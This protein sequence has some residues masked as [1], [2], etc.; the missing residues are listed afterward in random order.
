MCDNTE[1]WALREC[2]ALRVDKMVDLQSPRDYRDPGIGRIQ[3]MVD[4]F[5]QIREREGAFY[6][7]GLAALLQ[8]YDKENTSPMRESADGAKPSIIWPGGREAQRVL[9]SW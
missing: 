7:I 6:D 4:A 5:I 9:A 2:G 8:F 3:D 1:Q